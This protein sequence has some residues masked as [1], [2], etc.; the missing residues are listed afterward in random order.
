[1]TQNIWDEGWYLAVVQ[2]NS[3]SDIVSLGPAG[4]IHLEVLQLIVWPN[5]RCGNTQ[6]PKDPD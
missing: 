5:T 6:T 3:G 2:R 1:M 4:F